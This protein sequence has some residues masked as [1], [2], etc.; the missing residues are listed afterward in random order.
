MSPILNDPRA[1]PAVPLTIEAVNDQV[2][3]TQ[4][5]CMNYNQYCIVI[6]YLPRTI[7]AGETC[8]I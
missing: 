2:G 1:K 8:M 7:D 6:L 3:D 5:N 4:I